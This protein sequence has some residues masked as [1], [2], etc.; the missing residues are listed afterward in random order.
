MFWNS[1]LLNNL[2]SL[3]LYFRIVFIT[4][5]QCTL[6]N[7]KKIP[8]IQLLHVHNDCNFNFVNNSSLCQ[9][10]KNLSQKWPSIIETFK[11]NI[12]L[13]IQQKTHIIIQFAAK[14][15]KYKQFSLWLKKPS[16]MTTSTTTITF[17]PLKLKKKNLIRFYRGIVCIILL[18]IGR[19]FDKD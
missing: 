5:V 1:W 16:R 4:K 13:H 19:Y 7:E 12:Q 3:I 18:S 2:V 17:D 9:I 8:Y 11:A 14:C 6:C 15:C 10:Y